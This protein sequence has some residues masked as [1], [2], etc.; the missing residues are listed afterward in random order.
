L[1]VGLFAPKGTPPQG[2]IHF[3]RAAIDKAAHSD[4]FTT[5]LTNLGLDLAYLDGPD[6]G[7]VSGTPISSGFGE[8][9][10]GDRPQ[11]RDSFFE[12][13]STRDRLGR[14]H[15]PTMYTSAWPSPRV[16]S[17]PASTPF[18]PDADPRGCSMAR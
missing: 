1:W 10:A 6:F 14:N 7:D 3:G 5:T 9:V 8:A 18:V 16:F 4:Q 13:W 17:I 2:R 12:I 15:G 11:C